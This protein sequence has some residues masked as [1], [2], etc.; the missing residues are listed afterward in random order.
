[1]H[2]VAKATLSDVLYYR[3]NR[4]DFDCN[5]TLAGREGGFP[6]FG[7]LPLA[8]R[9][10]FIDATEAED[11]YVVRSYDTPIAWFAHGQWH[12]PNVKYSPTTSR[13]LSA[14]GLPTDWKATGNAA[15][16][17]LR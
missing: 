7:R 13:H 8:Y 1:M 5:R 6:S 11:F 14:L 3:I 15:W 17:V 2:T 10:D 16:V 9:V 12:V 4:I